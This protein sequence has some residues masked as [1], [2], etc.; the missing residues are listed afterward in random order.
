MARVSNII[1][2]DARWIVDRMGPGLAP[3]SGKTFVVTGAAGFLCSVLVDTLAE[4]NTRLERPCKVIAVDNYQSAVPDRLEHL[5]DRKDIVLVQHDVS[6]PF[7]AKEP[8]HYVL[9]GASVASPTFYRK[10]PL[11]T[12][13]VNVQGTRQ[14]LELARTH[15]EVESV[16]F[17]STSEIYGDPTPDMIPT[18]EDYRG[19]V[20]C[21][22]PR[23]CYDESKRLGETLCSTYYRLY[24]TPV[25]VIRPF[26][27]Y[28][29]GQRLDDKRI[30]P[31]LMSA[32][33]SKKPLVLLSD[34][35]ATRA[36]CYVRDAIWGM[37]HVTVSKADGEAFNVGND[38]Q[39]LSM[40][41]VAQRLSKV[42]AK[43][44]NGPEL[45]VKYEKSE[46]PHYLSD[47]PQRRCPNLAKLRGLAGH[48][49]WS[50]Q[51]M[52]N[53]GLERTLRSYL[54]TAS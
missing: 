46:D 14:F 41:D 49:P 25:K 11:E 33:L 45:E 48:A 44:M 1:R 34:G 27:V 2:E 26:N 35:R 43:V 37:L 19:F 6:K 21:T 12:I 3:L 15:S 32:A 29:P 47:N 8:V 54:E 5:K 4:L 22:G 30:M 20:S 40:L 18:Q 36:L 52:L 38:E 53:E 13:D 39:E 51:V 24:K 16:V 28:G 7:D 10:Y 17:M 50:P 23:A 9:H 42:A 31:D